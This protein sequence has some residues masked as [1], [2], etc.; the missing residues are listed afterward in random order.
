MLSSY[1]PLHCSSP[2]FFGIE[3]RHCT[4]I[5]FIYLM[6]MF[7]LLNEYKN[8][9]S[10]L[11]SLP[12]NKSFT[13]ISSGRY[14]P[15]PEPTD[16]TG[17]NSRFIAAGQSPFLFTAQWFCIRVPRDEG[18][19]LCVSLCLSVCLSVCFSVYPPVRP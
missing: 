8:V 7:L 19:S 5:T 13:W 16:G 3:L 6:T 2:P 18:V 9:L 10:Y 15:F 14:S 12:L 11:H 1:I 4:G 17:D